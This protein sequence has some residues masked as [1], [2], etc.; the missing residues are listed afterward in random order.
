MMSTIL[1]RIFLLWPIFYFIY[2]LVLDQLGVDPAK[3]L[4][5][6][7]GQVVFYYIMLNLLIGIVISFRF[8]FLKWLSVVIKNRRYLGVLS[9]LIL[10]SH[11]LFYFIFEGFEKK[12]LQQLYT[13]TY[14][15]FAVLAFIILLVL[16]LTSNNYSVKKLGMRNWKKIHKGV[17]IAFVFFGI[18]ILLIE[19]AD[20]LKYGVLLFI[21]SILQIVRFF[22]VN[23]KGS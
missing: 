22:Q 9:F 3:S 19:K 17:Y 5:H 18:H 2:L 4:A 21:M 6:Q 12:A 23:K 1:F 14:L 13:K 8:K 10:I 15:I 20:I 11:V 16:T 7:T